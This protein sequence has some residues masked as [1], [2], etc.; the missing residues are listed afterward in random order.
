MYFSH[1]L[2]YPAM[3][4]VIPMHVWRSKILCLLPLHENLIASSVLRFP[5]SKKD[6][7]RLVFADARRKLKTFLSNMPPGCVTVGRCTVDNCY[8]PKKLFVWRGDPCL[9][10]TISPYCVLH[11]R[12]YVHGIKHFLFQ[13]PL[14]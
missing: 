4:R 5:M 1:D 7:R 2:K 12:K 13:F 3:Y 6:K 9:A 11:T 14:M 10:T 8:H